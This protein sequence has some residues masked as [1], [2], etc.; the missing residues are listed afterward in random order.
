MKSEELTRVVELM[1]FIMSF[2]DDDLASDCLVLCSFEENSIRLKQL[3]NQQI[4]NEPLD[5]TSPYF[6]LRKY[7]LEGTQ[8]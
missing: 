2:C 7:L 3:S 4:V 8:S 5:M 1:N 6:Y